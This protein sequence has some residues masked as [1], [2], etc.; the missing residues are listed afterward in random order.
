[1]IGEVLEAALHDDEAMT[2]LTSCRS[3][4]PSLSTSWTFLDHAG[5]LRRGPLAIIEFDTPS[6]IATPVLRSD[7]GFVGYGRTAGGAT[8]FVIP[9][10]RIEDLINISTRVAP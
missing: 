2:F 7:P 3:S 1:M 6:G 9:N 10:Y 4:S 5:N 8:E